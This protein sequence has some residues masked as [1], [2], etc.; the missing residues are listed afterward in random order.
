MVFMTCTLLEHFFFSSCFASSPRTVSF[1]LLLQLFLLFYQVLPFLSL[2]F[3]SSFF[4]RCLL[5]PLL[6]LQE[7]LTIPHGLTFFS[8]LHSFLPFSPI[9]FSPLHFLL[10]SFFISLSS[11][12]PSPS[13]TPSLFL[14]IFSF[15][16]SSTAPTF[17]L[18]LLLLLFC[19]A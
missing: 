4:H 5:S 2:S 11:H 14:P 17:T 7:S 6:F 8:S 3:S 18:R 15:I 12:F 19:L 16:L 13:M 10:T 9:P 1:L